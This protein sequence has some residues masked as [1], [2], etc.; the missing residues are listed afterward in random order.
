MDGCWWAVLRGMRPNGGYHD[1]L[2]RET[3][4]V[5]VV[6]EDGWP[7]FAPGEGRVPAEVDVPFAGR[8]QPGLG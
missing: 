8:L 1:N 6:W 5:P 2:G 3:F 7:V 4:L